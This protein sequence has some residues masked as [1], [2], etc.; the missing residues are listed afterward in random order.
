MESKNLA[1]K[2]K[3]SKN[4]QKNDK[5]TSNFMQKSKNSYDEE[6]FIKLSQT[7]KIRFTLNCAVDLLRA[8]ILTVDDVVD[9]LMNLI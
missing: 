8:N 3:I 5:K 4:L 7:Q 9:L 6:H 2:S 1:K